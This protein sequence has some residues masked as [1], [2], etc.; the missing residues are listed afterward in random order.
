MYKKEQ[1]NKLAEEAWANKR[2]GADVNIG[3]ITRLETYALETGQKEYAAIASLFKAFRAY[4]NHQYDDACTLGDQILYEIPMYCSQLWQA[5][6]YYALGLFASS[7]NKLPSALSYWKDGLSIAETIDDTELQGYLIYNIAD[8]N[9]AIFKRYDLAK[10]FYK[11]GLQL[12]MG[13]E[14][15]ILCGL[16]LI[17]LS[18]CEFLE[19]NIEVSLTH[20][21][22]ALELSLESQDERAIGICYEFAGSRY[23]DV[24]NFEKA[25]LY[26]SKSVENRA[27]RNDLYGLV[28]SYHALSNCSFQE[29]QLESALN[30]IEMAYQHYVT[31]NTHVLDDLLFK[32]FAQV[33]EG[34]GDWQQASTYY[35]A[36]A[37]AK[38]KSISKE[39]EDLMSVMAAEYQLESAKKDAEI[40]RLKNEAL[41]EKNQEITL[42]ASELEQALEDLKETQHELVRTSRLSGLLGLIVGIA[43]QINTPLGNSITLSSYIEDLLNSLEASFENLPKETM[44]EIRISFYHL[45][46]NL[47]KVANIVESLKKFNVSPEKLHY[48]EGDIVAFISEWLIDLH[49][50]HHRLDIQL[51]VEPHQNFICKFEPI[52]LKR[53]LFE[54]FTNVLNHAYEG[55]A[56]CKIDL[57]VDSNDDAIIL[58]IIDHGI[59]MALDEQHELFEPF[60][61][62]KTAT[63][64]LGLGLHLVYLLTTNVLRGDVSIASIPGEY[65]DVTLTLKKHP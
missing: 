4:Y 56:T 21:D 25:H 45:R 51:Q 23:A 33:Y 19:N 36:Y 24:G 57:K 9:R 15:H 2:K 64:G 49:I 14:K 46:N 26:L 17:G 29:G 11:K 28:N 47:N 40:Y 55:Q 8:M 38:N 52:S 34:L 48:K 3:S 12:C 62:L 53:V 30:Y 65:C 50:E 27:K 44:A 42:L 32:Q 60:K 1:I 37:E 16:M 10:S 58:H 35:K 7:K 41:K 31:L 39:L 18:R 61:T 59:G 54:L 5:R 13:S 20:A 43:H 22:R 6:M 63:S